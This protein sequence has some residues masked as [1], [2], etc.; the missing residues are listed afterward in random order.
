[1]IA[2]N[3]WW[4]CVA[5]GCFQHSTRELQQIHSTGTK[6]LGGPQQQ[7][8][9]WAARGEEGNQLNFRIVTMA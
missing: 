7:I 4:I 8:E 5:E 1:M 2:N 9:I 6:S 3:W